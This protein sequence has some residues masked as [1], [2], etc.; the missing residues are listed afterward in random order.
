MLDQKTITSGGVEMKEENIR[1][2]SIAGLKSKT[3]IGNGFTLIE[4]IIVIAII[5]IL[6]A[7]LM[8][9]LKTAKNSAKKIL[10]LGNLRQI[11]LVTICHRFGTTRPDRPLALDLCFMSGGIPWGAQKHHHGYGYNFVFFDGSGRWQEEPGDHMENYY[12]WA[13]WS[14]K[15]KEYPG[16]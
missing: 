5:A 16:E 14:A 4:L 8:P 3:E 12:A 1:R 10:C 9:S 6:A 15:M 2:Q 11:G 13:L 7:M